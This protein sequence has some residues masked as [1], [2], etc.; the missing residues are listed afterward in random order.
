M[1]RIEVC[2]PVEDSSPDTKKPP[3]RE[4]NHALGRGYHQC[5]LSQSIMSGIDEDRD[6]TMNEQ[7]DTEKQISQSME[8]MSNVSQLIIK[9]V[10]EKTSVLPRHH[11]HIEARKNTLRSRFRY[12]K[13]IV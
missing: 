12:L 2:I 7:N 5:N 11:A 9:Q 13:P 1:V 8:H 6:E 4:K 3:P 10:E